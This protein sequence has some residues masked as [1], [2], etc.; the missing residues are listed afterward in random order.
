MTVAL[1]VPAAA[2]SQSSPAAVNLVSASYFAILA[3]SLVSNI[4]TSAVTDDIG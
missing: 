3:D 2:V 1:M 4:P